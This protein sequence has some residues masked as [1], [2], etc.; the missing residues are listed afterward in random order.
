MRNL[1]LLALA[2][3][4][5]AAADDGGRRHGPRHHHGPP[6]LALVVDRH[7]D[8]LGLDATTT[9]TV[10]DIAE[11]ARP[12]FEG[13][14]GEVRSARHALRIA[15]ESEITDEA[16]VFAASAAVGDAEQALR[17]HRLSV[18]LS[19]KQ[20]LTTDQLAQLKSFRPERPSRR[21]PPPE[22]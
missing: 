8:D 1:L 6:P 5:M 16:A 17:D 20:L 12:M 3:P 14:V 11:A 7:A 18:D 4:S 13:L 10:S 19:I 21:G 2:L 9:Q 15:M 22:L